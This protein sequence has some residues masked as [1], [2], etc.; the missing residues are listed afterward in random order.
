MH[1]TNYVQWYT[2]II[3]V[4]AESFVYAYMYNI[5]A[6]DVNSSN[7]PASWNNQYNFISF[8][9]KGIYKNLPEW[10]LVTVSKQGARHP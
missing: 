7:L 4:L 9:L 8:Y 6:W 3:K 10:A 5:H 1:Y 2:K